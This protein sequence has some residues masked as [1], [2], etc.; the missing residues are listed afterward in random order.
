[1]F[2]VS[3]LNGLVARQEVVR[4]QNDD[5]NVPG[6]VH[7]NPNHYHSG[8]QLA[9]KRRKSR[10]DSERSSSLSA[11]SGGSYCSDDKEEEETETEN[12]TQYVGHFRGV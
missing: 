5:D 10:D 11:G 2:Q 12:S 7:L 4:K 8:G 6:L 3:A 1:L 9:N